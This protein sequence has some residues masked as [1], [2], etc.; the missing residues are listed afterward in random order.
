MSSNEKSEKDDVLIVRKINKVLYRRFKERAVRDGQT[1]GQALNQAMIS[2]LMETERKDRQRI[3]KLTKLNGLIKAEGKV[4][5][6]KEI[7]ETLY[8]DNP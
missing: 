5:W 8:G 3:G 7:D 1:V 6:S 4:A 2:W